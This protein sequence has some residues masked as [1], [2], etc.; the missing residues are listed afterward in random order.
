MWIP[1]LVA[2]SAL[3]ATGVGCRAIF[4]ARSQIF[5]PLLFRGPRDHPPRV[6]LT[7]DDG[8][9]HA[10]TPRILDVLRDHGAVATFFVVGRHVAAH[11]GLL[12]RMHGEGHAIANHSMDHSY[13]GLFHGDRYWIDQINCTDD[14]IEGIIGVRTAMFRPPMGFKTFHV[15]RAAR[16]TGHVMVTWT[17]RGR[18]G[19]N[20]SANQIVH[21]LANATEPGDIVLL[22]DGMIPGVRRDPLATVD[23]L[24]ALIEAWRNRRLALVRLDELLGINAYQPTKRT[25]P[26]APF[27]AEKIS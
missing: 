17:R 4:A 3:A 2:G 18:D 24:V 14:I 22:H 26:S 10:A 20:T 21:R 19:V 11:S 15:T 25:T 7:F 6:A 13:G 23:A 5:G 27:L 16:K 8:P 12:R 1:L 9:H